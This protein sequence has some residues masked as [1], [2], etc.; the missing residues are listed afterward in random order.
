MQGN[1]FR[2]WVKCFVC[3]DR[4]VSR[5]QD[6]KEDL[7]N[8]EMS[9]QLFHGSLFP[10]Q[11]AMDHHSSRNP[12]SSY[13]NRQSM[14]AYKR[15]HDDNSGRNHCQNK[16]ATHHQNKSGPPPAQNPLSSRGLSIR[17]ELYE[18]DFPV[19]KQPVEVGGF[20]LD[21]QRRFF[22]DSRQLRYYVEPDR[23]PNFDLRDGYKDRFVKRDDSVKEKLDHV[24]RWILANRLKLSSRVTTASPW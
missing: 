12:N 14:S 16:K 22:N 19:Y 10:H 7:N 8:H 4:S 11:A 3:A 17:R 9:W 18:R 24:L 20:S 13:Q 15:K 6:Y 23:N 2:W 21:S 5:I 1:E